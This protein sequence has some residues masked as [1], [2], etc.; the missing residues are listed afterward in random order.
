MYFAENI[1]DSEDNSDG[2]GKLEVAE[3]NLLIDE[4]RPNE[5]RDIGSE[6]AEGS[7]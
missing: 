5:D 2:T 3:G 4:G 6:E 7:G 1:A